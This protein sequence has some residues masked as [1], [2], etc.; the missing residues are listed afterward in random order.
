MMT[1]EKAQQ[2]AKY[3]KSLCIREMKTVD[4]D[5]ALADFILLQRKN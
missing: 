4:I 5:V 2:F 3:Y 1:Y